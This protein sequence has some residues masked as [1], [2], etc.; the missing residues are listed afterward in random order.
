MSTLPLKT[1]AGVVI[2]AAALIIS[3]WVAVGLARS[4]GLAAAAARIERRSDD[5]FVRALIA[6]AT[7]NSVN[8]P[9]E[10]VAEPF[11]DLEW[12]VD[13]AGSRKLA[14]IQ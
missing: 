6:L 7:L 1:I 12:E 5:A 14:H 2:P 11:R 4:E 3:T 10:G 13:A 8:L 9:L